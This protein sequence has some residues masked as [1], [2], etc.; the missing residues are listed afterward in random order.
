MGQLTK[1]RRV[2]ALA[3]RSIATLNPS[4]QVASFTRVWDGQPRVAP[5]RRDSFACTIGM[6]IRFCPENGDLCFLLP[7]FAM[8]FSAVEDLMAPR[9]FRLTAERNQ[10]G[11]KM[12]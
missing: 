11:K 9:R 12:A 4:I 10:C 6:L 1:E 3:M 5:G 8:I 7:I 2:P